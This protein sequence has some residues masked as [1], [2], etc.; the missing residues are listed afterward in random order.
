MTDFDNLLRLAREIPAKKIKRG[1][2]ILMDGGFVKVDSILQDGSRRKFLDVRGETIIEVS[3][4]NVEV[5]A[6]R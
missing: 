1:H 4:G 5:L 3:N 6:G 2:S